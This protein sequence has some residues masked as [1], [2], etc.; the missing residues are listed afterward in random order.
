MAKQRITSEARTNA[1]PVEDSELFR[2]ATRRNSP[3]APASV[4]SI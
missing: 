2:L 4:Q 1:L 3:G